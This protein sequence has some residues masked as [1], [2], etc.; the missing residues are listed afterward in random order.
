MTLPVLVNH[1][2][3][4]REIEFAL[5][6]HIYFLA[7]LFQ[8]GKFSGRYYIYDVESQGSI[9]TGSLDDILSF[10]FAPSITLR[11]SISQYNFKYIM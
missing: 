1:L 8:D 4:G 2:L 10:E 3:N 7:P 5:D 6:S 11:S 9:F